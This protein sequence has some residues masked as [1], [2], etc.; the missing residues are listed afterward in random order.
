MPHRNMK[1]HIS[2]MVKID[3]RAEPWQREEVR[4]AA[5][6]ADMTMQ[7]FVIKTLLEGIRSN[8]SERGIRGNPPP[9]AKANP[10]DAESRGN[11]KP[12]RSTTTDC[13]AEGSAGFGGDETPGRHDRAT[14]F[15]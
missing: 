8:G 15:E 5:A 1:N 13:N 7:A 10:Q 4:K 2:G 9:N 12:N 11:T 3:V 14:E 6:R